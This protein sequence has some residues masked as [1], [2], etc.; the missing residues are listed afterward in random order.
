MPVFRQLILGVTL[1][2]CLLSHSIRAQ[3]RG[4]LPDIMPLDTLKAKWPVIKVAKP[5]VP[6]TFNF[7]KYQLGVQKAKEFTPRRVPKI[8]RWAWEN[9]NVFN[10]NLNE[11]AFVNWNAGGNSAVSVSGNL[12]LFRYLTYKYLS[13]KNELRVGYGINAQENTRLRKAEDYVRFTST[14]SYRRDTL[15]NWFYSVKL[16]FNTQMDD[17]FKYPNR[18]TPISRFMAPG[19]VFFGMGTSYIIGNNKFNLYMSPVTMKSTLVL[20]QTLANQGA[21]GVQ[22]AELDADGNILVPGENLFMELG[23]LI[24]HDWETKIAKNVFMDHRLNL[25]TDYLRKFGNVDVN[26]ELTFNLV[27]NEHIKTDVGFQLIYDDDI[28]FDRE[29]DMDGNVINPGGARTQLRQFLAVGMSY[30]F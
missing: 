9:G 29:V 12:R 17:G 21:F 4:H 23:I 28:K 27:V 25:Y 19:Y 14:F 8:P 16:D 6:L 13:W 11:T 24:T 18:E 30:T 10:V 2:S 5:R 3:D 7:A 1:L 20:D 15:T 26:W 22:K